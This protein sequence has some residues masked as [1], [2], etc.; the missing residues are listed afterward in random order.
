MA[1]HF[2]PAA[3]AGLFNA[4]LH[5][6]PIEI[7]APGVQL[8][9]NGAYRE[10]IV[11]LMLSQQG[12]V[13]IF[14]FIADLAPLSPAGKDLQLGQI[15]HIGTDAVFL[16]NLAD[17]FHGF[18]RLLGIN[19][20]PASLLDD[21]CFLPGDLRQGIAQILGM[22]KGNRRNGAHIRGID[23]VGGIQL[24]PHAHFQHHHIAFL[25]GKIVKGHGGVKL[26][27]GDRPVFL[28]KLTEQ[29]GQDAHLFRQ[30]LF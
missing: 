4:L 21:S 5:I 13:Q 8:F 27:L 20:H 30:I 19:G 10:G 26:K 11:D 6:L 25:S 23:A 9:K 22:I 1:D 15:G 18:F 7:P 24:A 3:E 16:T 2:L 28:L 12:D 17:H 29:R 14:A